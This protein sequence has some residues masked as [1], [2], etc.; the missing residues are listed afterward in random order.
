[1]GSQDTRL[2][3]STPLTVTPLSLLDRLRSEPDQPSW[4]RLVSLYTPLI[5]DTIA[6]FDVQS[7]DADDLT[8]EVFA[9]VTRSMGTFEHNG[10]SGAF[11]NWLR[12]VVVHRVRVYWETRRRQP[13]VEVGQ[14]LT[15]LEDPSSNLCRQWDREHDA[16]VLR[17]LLDLLKVEF[18]TSTWEA[19]CRQV[20]DEVAPSIVAEELGLTINAVRIAKWRVQR[21]MMQE[22]AGLID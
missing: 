9:V 7:A 21:R 2:E 8:Q 16:F 5:R 22:V 17:R 6:R 10:R 15:E 13:L 14:R 3:D 18:T 4:H 19:F 11:R 20:F 1:M 12:S